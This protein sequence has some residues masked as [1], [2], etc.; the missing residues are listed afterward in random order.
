[1][2]DLR[3]IDILINPD[4]A[5]LEQARKVNARLRESVPDGFALDDTHHPHITTLQRYVRTADLDRVYASVEQVIGAT[6]T[7]ALGYQ[8]VAIGHLDWG[9]PGQGLAGFV[10]QPSRQVL[11]FQAALIAAVQPFTGSGG[12]AAAYV[13][14]PE[15]PDIN[16]TTLTYVERFVPDHSGPGYIAHITLGFATLHDLKAIEAEPFAAFPI[17]P[18]SI[19]VFHLGDNGTARKQLKAW[20]VTS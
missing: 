20:P 12:T 9:V 15:D 7:A 19:A 10:V 13:T 17:H 18:A 6:D 4:D 1:M 14:G 3:A 5:T 11:D 2:S 16:D 8:A